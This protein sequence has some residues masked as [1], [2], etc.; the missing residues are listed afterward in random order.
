MA[1]HP[2]VGMVEKMR[3]QEKKQL[4]LEY[5]YK[6]MEED[7]A[8]GSDLKGFRS[9]T[10]IGV[11]ALG[12]V[13]YNASSKASPVCKALIAE[14]MIERH[15]MGW[16]C[17]SSKGIYLMRR[18]KERERQRSVLSEKKKRDEFTDVPN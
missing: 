2:A 18:K 12:V 7:K 3:M 15:H 17:L 16:Y 1:C 13:R 8:I 14:V 11:E 4:V 5:L 10:Q 9:P 6:T